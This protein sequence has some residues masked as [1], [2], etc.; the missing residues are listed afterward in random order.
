M[1]T[2]QELAEIRGIASAPVAGRTEASRRRTSLA[3]RPLVVGIAI[4]LA[5]TAAVAAGVLTVPTVTGDV[6]MPAESS[7]SVVR[8]SPGPSA[9]VPNA[10]HIPMPLASA[11]HRPTLATMPVTPIPS[12]PRISDP[13]SLPPR[14]APETTTV[15]PSRG[16]PGTVFRFSFTGLPAN[17]A[18]IV[19][20]I[21]PHGTIGRSWEGTVPASGALVLAWQSPLDAPTG[22]WQVGIAAAGHVAQFREF[23]LAR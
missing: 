8:A 20:L 7:A 22:S 17:V 12:R 19:Q 10:V 3:V 16:T 9:R 5:A 21:A 11:T 18:Y 23:Q 14:P 13:Q 4:V 1:L 15:S 6:R 2:P